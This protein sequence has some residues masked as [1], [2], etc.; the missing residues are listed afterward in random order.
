MIYDIHI[1]L[2][3]FLYTHVILINQAAGV[4]SYF[5][6]IDY[7]ATP[8]GTISTKD[9]L[10]TYDPTLYQLIEEVWPCHNI[11]LKRCVANR[12]N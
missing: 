11:Y 9:R 1:L 2:V 4:Q 5:N 3:F 12:G 8:N 6:A 10:R 7:S